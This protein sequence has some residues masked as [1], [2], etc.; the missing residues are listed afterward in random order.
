MP[1]LYTPVITGTKA[2]NLINTSDLS[3]V[4]AQVIDAMKYQLNDTAAALREED[5]QIRADMNNLIAANDALVFK[6]VINGTN[7]SPGAYTPAANCGD[8]YKVATGG[9][10]NGQKVE[11]GDTFICI[12]DST[13]IALSGTYSTVQNNWII[14]QTNTDGI[15]IGPASST[16]GNIATFNGTTGKLIQDSGKSFT[17]AS[18]SS[19]STDATIPTSKA[20]WGLIDGL[21]VSNIS[22]FGAGKTL[23]A[24]SEANGKISAT[25]QDISIA[26]SQ[27]NDTIPVSKGGTGMTTTTN[28]NAVVIGNSTTATNAMQTV[29]TD[30]GAFY[31]T[32]ANAKPK[33]GTLPVGQGGTG[34]TTFTSNAVLYGNGTNAI[35]TKA[36][37]NGALYATSANGSLSWGTLPVQQGGTGLTTATTVNAVVIGNSTTA[38]NAL[39]TV[40]T[41]SGAFYAE[42]T[43]G[44][45]KFGTLPVA[46][47]G[48]GATSFTANSVVISGSSTTSALTTRAITNNTTNTSITNNNTNI[49]TMN[50]IYYGLATINGASQ[51]RSVGVYA[52]TSAGTEGQVLSSSG[53]GAPTWV[54]SSTV[55]SKIQIVR[56]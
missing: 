45:P 30:N 34:A 1:V 49:P 26:P 37:A 8:V 40:A 42:A 15:V 23:S 3:F 31:A 12:A 5:G 9:Y 2:F 13:P 32:A 14:L 52:P 20:V 36:S 46:Q 22:G 7:T 4:L 44:K 50:T 55:G 6:G 54:D 38:N 11:I 56:W 41:A 28:V 51:N 10:I 21:D 29:A 17:T 48:T 35:Q 27:I 16:S 33:F 25:F 47:G 39:Q 18:P 43:N 53:S 24:L 19:S